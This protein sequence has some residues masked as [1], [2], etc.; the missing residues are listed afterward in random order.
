MRKTF[1]QS[2]RHRRLSAMVVVRWEI[3][4]RK[5]FTIRHVL[6]W[7]NIRQH[8][9]NLEWESMFPRMKFNSIIFSSSKAD[10][11]G[12]A[13]IISL[14][15]TKMFFKNVKRRSTTISMTNSFHCSAGKCQ[16]CVWERK[17]NMR[18]SDI[19]LI[20]NTVS[21]AHWHSTKNGNPIILNRQWWK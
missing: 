21:D 17:R 6:P 19:K 4:R 5:N 8:C 15:P 20:R 10:R 7:R 11:K 9:T 18:R 3:V 13:F 2:C 12:R 16:G 14:P 1:A